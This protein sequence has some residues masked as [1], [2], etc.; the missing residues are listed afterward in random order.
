M[1]L[2]AKWDGPYLLSRIS[3][4]GVSG[5]LEDLKTGKFIGRYAF[6]SLKVYVPREQRCQ[7]SGWVTLAQGLP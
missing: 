4:S 2:H 3:K 7:D 6:E 1:K 5:D